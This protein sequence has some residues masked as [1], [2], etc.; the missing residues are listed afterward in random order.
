MFFPHPLALIALGAISAFLAK[1]QGKNPILWFFLGM[2]FGIFG[3]LFLFFSNSS[4]IQQSKR[5][6]K[7]QKDPNTIDITPKV[8]PEAKAKFWYYLDSENAQ[9]GPISYNGLVQAYKEGEISSLS[10]VW[11]ETLDDWKPFSK[12]L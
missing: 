11:N 7:K 1:R 9:K 2:F 5:E 12:F 10:F 8:E 4:S 3:L 6:T